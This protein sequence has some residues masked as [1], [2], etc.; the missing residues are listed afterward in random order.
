MKKKYNYKQ[1]NYANG[2]DAP[3]ESFGIPWNAQIK[4]CRI[5][6]ERMKMSMGRTKNTDFVQLLDLNFA[7]SLWAPLSPL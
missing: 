4:V 3:K 7:F 6:K 1:G 5:R 2:N